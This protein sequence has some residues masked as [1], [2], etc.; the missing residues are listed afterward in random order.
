MKINFKEFQEILSQEETITSAAKKYAQKN[1]LQYSDTL[2]RRFSKLLAKVEQGVDSDLENDTVTGTNQ[3]SNDKNKPER[4]FTAIDDDGSLMNI[5]RYCEY[6]GLDVSKIRSYKL[7][8][9]QNVPYLNIVFFTSEEQ[10]MVDV[11][12]HLDEIIPKYIKPVRTIAKVKKEGNEMWFDR[13]VFTDAHLAMDVNGNGDPL[14][15]GK[16]DRET[17]LKRAQDMVNHVLEYN[18]SDTLYID[19][20]GD[21]LDGLGG[22]TTRKGHKLPQNMNDKQAFELALDFNMLIL[23]SLIQTYDKIVFNIL[24]NDNHSGVFAFFAA[25]AFK[26]VAE[27]KYPNRVEINVLKRFIEHYTVGKHTFVI[28]HG[29]DVGELK[30]GYKPKLDAIQAEKLDQY[31]KEHK[32]YTGNYIEV[33]KGDSHQGVYDDSTS[34]DFQYYNYPAFS[35]PSNWVKTNFGNSISGF[36]FYNIHKEKN[37]KITIPYFF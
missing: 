16:W 10:A 6:Y 21:W 31:C 27:L 24:T 28:L 18:K 15:D 32:L 33:G 34:K 25:T 30:F 2:R 26:R 35:P 13:L 23:D 36:R 11:E 22:E 37:I 9:H 14:Y 19:N 7:I 5:E 17:A 4:G 8:T 12:K 1:D 20:L 29:K 3:Y